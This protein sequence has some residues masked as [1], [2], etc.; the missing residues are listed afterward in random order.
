MIVLLLITVGVSNMVIGPNLLPSKIPLSMIFFPVSATLPLYHL[1]HH[2][3]HHHHHLLLLLLLLL[4]LLLLLLLLLL[5]LL[6]ISY[7]VCLLAMKRCLALQA[8]IS[9]VTFG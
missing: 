2:H 9:V 3:H 7:R 5:F 6:A 8:L 1:H 4:P